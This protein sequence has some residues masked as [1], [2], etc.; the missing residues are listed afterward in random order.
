ML[1]ELFQNNYLGF[2]QQETGTHLRDAL[3]RL[4]NLLNLQAK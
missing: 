3:P 1:K 4:T 2:V